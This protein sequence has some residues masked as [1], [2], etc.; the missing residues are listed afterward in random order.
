MCPN[1]SLVAVRAAH[2]FPYSSADNG[3][4]RCRI[5]KQCFRSLGVRV[6]WIIKLLLKIK[7]NLNVL[8]LCVVWA[9]TNDS[10]GDT[11]ICVD[12]AVYQG[13]LCP[14]EEC[15]C[16]VSSIINAKQIFLFLLIV[17]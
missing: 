11:V 15:T 4:G 12:D 6:G 3:T 5:S 9:D 1:F 7:A 13:S 8:V 10:I 17:L 2:Y 14:W 16:D